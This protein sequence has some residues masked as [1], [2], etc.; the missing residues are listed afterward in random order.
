MLFFFRFQIFRENT[1]TF[2]SGNLSNNI[3]L[4][5]RRDLSQKRAA[6]LCYFFSVSKSFVKILSL[7][8]LATFQ[9]TFCF[10]SAATLSQKRAANMQ[11]AFDIAKCFS[12]KLLLFLTNTVLTRAGG[13]F[14]FDDL[15]QFCF[16][17]ADVLLHCHPFVFFVYLVVHILM[18]FAF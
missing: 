6:K 3:L 17:V 4:S 11:Y 10:P 12:K 13:R 8:S 5:V 7:F 14:F 16:V 9:T 15:F 2:F 18:S 1:F